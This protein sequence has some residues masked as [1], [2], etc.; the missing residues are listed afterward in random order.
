MKKLLVIA[1]LMLALVF[2]AVACNDDPVTEDTTL[3]DTTVETP[4][5]APTA[6]PED[7]TEPTE[8]TAEPE[9][10]TE[11]PE[12]TTEEVTTEEETTEEVTTADPADPVWIMNADDLAAM[13]N[14]VT[15]SVEKTEE[16]FA[17]FTA[18]GA[19][20][21]FLLCNNIGEMPS[22]WLSATAPTPT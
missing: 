12:E 17:S 5:E 4:T 13:A 3:G 2:T 18:T 10:T 14:T 19:D 16:G 6:E 22:I 9:E 8:T 20:P 15:S 1:I 7:P 21:W 11:E